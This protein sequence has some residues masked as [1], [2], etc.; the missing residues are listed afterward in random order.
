MSHFLT[1]FFAFY[2]AILLANNL[3]KRGQK[4][5]KTQNKLI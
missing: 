2:Y 3:T 5:I 4:T 1:F